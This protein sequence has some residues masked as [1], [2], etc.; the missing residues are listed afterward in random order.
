[1]NNEKII[2]QKFLR[3]SQIL[4]SDSRRNGESYRDGN[5]DEARVVH[6]AA[7]EDGGREIRAIRELLETI[8]EEPPFDLPLHNFS[9]LLKGL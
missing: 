1:M 9:K 4:E 2:S 6:V 5:V 8:G 3:D 7:T